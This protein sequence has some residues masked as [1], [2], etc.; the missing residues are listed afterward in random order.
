M[1]LSASFS[2]ALLA[3]FGAAYSDL[4]RVTTRS[5]GNREDARELVHDTWLRLAEHADGAAGEGASP[6]DG[7]PAP[8]EVA[9]YLTT[10]AQNL[11]IDH[12]RRGQ[13]HARHVRDETV[14]IELAAPHVP[15]VAE[16]VMYAQALAAL[17][18]ALAKLPERTRAVFVAHRVQGE[19]QPLIAERLGVSV[20]TV[21]RDLI[22]ASACIEDALHRW[23]G[24]APGRA[25]PS[26]ATSPGRRRSLGALLGLAGL[27]AGG[28]LA[29]QQWC[30]YRD[31]QVQWALA[32]LSQRGQFMRYTLADGSAM[33]LDAMSQ[34]EVRYY[35]GRRVVQLSRGAA[36]FSVVRDE[37][38]P[39]IVEAGAVRA[40]VLGTRFGVERLGPEAGDAVL[41]QVESGRVRVE[42]PGMS[43]RMLG[44]GEGLRLSADGQVMPTAGQA[45]SWR[46]GELVFEGATLGQA[47]A[48][49]SRYTRSDLHATP[50][51]ARLPLSGR[52]RI[53]QAGAWLDALPRAM[54]VQLQRQPGGEVLVALQGE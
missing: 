37:A 52:V 40:T 22:Q 42:A 2:R 23:R 29:W 21:E 3:G 25:N 48:R 8:R 49:L 54:P 13:R 33:Q 47:L 27:G 26:A 34:A 46:E 28:T 5:T 19:K 15:D 17:Q 53:A 35:A 31:T 7:A 14:Q 20:N 41:V 30:V 11:A 1:D 18:T 44:A 12:L 9:A 32:A 43:P 16:S 6:A 36:F 51:A 4:L 39:F 10:M 24:T 50:G 45:A 38:R